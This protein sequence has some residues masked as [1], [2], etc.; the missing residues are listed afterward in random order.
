[1]Y[2]QGVQV[3]LL[4]KMASPEAILFTPIQYILLVATVTKCIG[5]PTSN[6]I[7]YTI[8]DFLLVPAKLKCTWAAPLDILFLAGTSEK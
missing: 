6:H 8:T 5:P 3:L 4:C 2:T 7:I 1:M